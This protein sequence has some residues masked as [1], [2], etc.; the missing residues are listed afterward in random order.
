MERP[1]TRT[2]M[3]NVPRISNRKRHLK[4]YGECRI[5]S[6]AE[7]RAALLLALSASRALQ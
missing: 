7:L 2:K 3:K 5:P 4:R 6:G 1:L